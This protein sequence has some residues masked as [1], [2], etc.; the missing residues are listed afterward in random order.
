MWEDNYRY[1]VDQ[2]SYTND[3]IWFGG[4]LCASEGEVQ[5]KANQFPP[6]ARMFVYY[7]PAHPADSVLHKGYTK[8]GATPLLVFLLLA[9]T[10]GWGLWHLIREWRAGT[11]PPQASSSQVPHAPRRH[12][13]EP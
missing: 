11:P 1:E 10:I 6:G 2:R 8:D 12:R 7:D 3:R 13:T 9:S 5:A 4:Q